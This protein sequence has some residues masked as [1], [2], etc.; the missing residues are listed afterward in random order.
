[1]T[2]HLHPSLQNP[3]IASH[4]RIDSADQSYLN[5]EVDL[6]EVINSIIQTY[7]LQ[8]QNAPVIFRLDKIPVVNGC[9]E[10]LHFLFDELI[11]MILSHPPDKSKLFLYM[12][13]AEEKVDEN[14]LDLRVMKTGNYVVCFHTN[15][16]TTEEWK[17]LYKSKLE[18]CCQVAFQNGGSLN[19]YNI[20]NTGCLFSL[21]LP[22]KTI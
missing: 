19:H 9:K 10:T 4:T 1:M 18:D 7:L 5:E 13:C 22:G 3:S 6:N 8:K 21:T 14:V 20:V 17:M 11:N 15:I 12:Q 2:Q 16:H